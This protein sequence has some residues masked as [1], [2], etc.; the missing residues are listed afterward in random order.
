MSKG[1]EKSVF[2]IEYEADYSDVVLT[3]EIYLT[4]KQHDFFYIKT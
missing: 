4:L 3:V 1:D 2:E